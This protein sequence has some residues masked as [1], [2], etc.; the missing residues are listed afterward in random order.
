M[1]NA[2]CLLSSQNAFH[3]EKAYIKTDL[4]VCVCATNRANLLRITY[5]RGTLA[6][7]FYISFQDSRGQLFVLLCQ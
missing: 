6:L 5:W 7:M 4:Y 1:Q 2:T 3:G